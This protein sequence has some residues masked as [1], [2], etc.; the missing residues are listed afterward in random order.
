MSDYQQLKSMLQQTFED[1]KVDTSE[2][3]ELYEVFQPL[4]R[5]QRAY[6]RNR[7]FELAADY[8]RDHPDV[9][10]PYK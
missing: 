1:Q 10:P 2:A 5:E 4:N 7:A 3:A 6:V 8:S 9:Y